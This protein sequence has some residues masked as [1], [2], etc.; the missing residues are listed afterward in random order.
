MIHYA[1]I[2]PYFRYSARTDS[3][4]K[5]KIRM[6]F[7]FVKPAELINFHFQESKLDSI[8]MQNPLFSGVSAWNN[9]L[10]QLI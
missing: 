3:K 5:K 8:L 9:R 1:F 7:K 2:V 10:I 6:T 4:M